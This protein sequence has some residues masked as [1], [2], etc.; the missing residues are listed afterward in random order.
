M[1]VWT[2]QN[3]TAQLP[4]LPSA[5][6]RDG[7]L[8]ESTTRTMRGTLTP[9]L[10]LS[11]TSLLDLGLLRTSTM[12]R[13]SPNILICGDA[14]FAYAT[15]LAKRL[16][17]QPVKIFASAYEPEAELLSRYPHAADAMESLTR[18]GVAVRCGVDARELRAHYEQ[19]FDRIVFNLPQS[20]PAPKARNQIQR[21]RALLRD[22]CGSAAECLAPRGEL[23]ITLL[24]GQGGTPLDPVQRLPGDTWQL[25]EQAAAGRLLVKA[26]G[27]ADL[28]ALSDAGYYATGRGRDAKA[29]GKKRK[30]K[31]LVV[32][33][34]GVEETPVRGDA[35][36]A[37]GGAKASSSTNVATDESMA[38]GVPAPAASAAVAPAASTAPAVSAVSAE[39]HAVASSSKTGC[40]SDAEGTQADSREEYVPVVGVAPLEGTRDN[41]FWLPAIP[42]EGSQTP[43]HHGDDLGDL[44]EITRRSQRGDAAAADAASADRMAGVEPSTD[45]MLRI[46]KSALGP[47]AEHALVA[48]PVLIDRYERPE[49]GRQARTYRFVYRSNKLALCHDR[50]SELNSVVCSAIE[51]SLRLD[52]RNPSAAPES[53]SAGAAPS[54]TDID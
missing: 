51:S 1:Y 38:A 5:P 27:S 20:P 44:E 23:W 34:L 32:H 11:G 4:F 12:W 3:V 53:E 13:T 25:Q 10:A 29:L 19:C 50:I 6:R 31:G 18:A 17:E 15:A 8:D 26:V 33:V 22:F 48:E 16:Q 49:D 47:H 46:C 41:S 35:R 52:H 54:E 7:R 40:G 30:Q 36:L 37:E 2:V 9:P 28:D 39:P 43:S 14:D 24:S 45:W 21:H 42:A